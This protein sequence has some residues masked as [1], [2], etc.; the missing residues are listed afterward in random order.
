ME[1]RRAV[2]LS[3]TY[4]IRGETTGANEQVRRDGGVLERGAVCALAH[5]RKQ[6]HGERGDAGVHARRGDHRLCRTEWGAMILFSGKVHE[7]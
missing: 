7:D 1:L 3:I 2:V 5:I 4:H 6:P